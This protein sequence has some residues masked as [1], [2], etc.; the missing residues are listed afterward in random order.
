[1]KT[2]FLPRQ[3][4]P[5]HSV[6]FSKGSYW[7]GALE[8]FSWRFLVVSV[9]FSQTVC[10]CL[11]LWCPWAA[12]THCIKCSPVQAGCEKSWALGER[13]QPSTPANLGPCVGIH[14]PFSSSSA[15][16]PGLFVLLGAGP[17]LM[18]SQLLPPAPLGLG[19]RR[20]GHI[21]KRGRILLPKQQIQVGI[22]P[23]YSVFYLGTES[24]VRKTQH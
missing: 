1:M 15:G 2:N 17:Q 5:D 16:L 24:D 22:L 3:A 21:W 6:I 13:K 20:C 14:P 9:K 19:K 8:T 18:G 23:W 12:L 4:F 7:T 11:L 10:F